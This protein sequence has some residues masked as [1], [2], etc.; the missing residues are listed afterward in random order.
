[1]NGSLP[2]LVMV[3]VLVTLMHSIAPRLGVPRLK[4]LC[5]VCVGGWA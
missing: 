5:H 2:V 3:L 1:M 4:P